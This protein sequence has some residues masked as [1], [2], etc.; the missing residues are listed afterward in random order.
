MLAVFS[1]SDVAGLAAYCSK[2]SCSAKC[3]A[4][5]SFSSR[6]TCA[7]LAAHVS[8]CSQRSET[9]GGAVRSSACGRSIT[10]ASIVLSPISGDPPVDGRN[11]VSIQSQGVLEAF[12][13]GPVVRLQMPGFMLQRA[14]LFQTG[15]GEV[16]TSARRDHHDDVV[17]GA[18]DLHQR[19]RDAG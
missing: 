7:R 10:V 9:F 4:M 1:R 17:F 6:C 19:A 3:V 18:P 14:E 2:K 8:W 13:F 11:T 5:R 15:L 16:R 12:A